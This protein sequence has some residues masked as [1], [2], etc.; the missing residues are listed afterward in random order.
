M[1]EEGRGLELKPGCDEW[2]SRERLF[3]RRVVLFRESLKA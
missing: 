1:K 2:R 3:G